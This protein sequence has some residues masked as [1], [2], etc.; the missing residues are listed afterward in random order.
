M[1]DPSEPIAVFDKSPSKQRVAASCDLNAIIAASGDNLGALVRDAPRMCIS[2]VFNLVDTQ[3]KN[4]CNEADVTKIANWFY[5]DA[6]Q[7]NPAKPADTPG[8]LNYVLY[9]RACYYVQSY[10]EKVVG[11][12]SS[13]MLTLIRYGLDKFFQRPNL[14]AQNDYHYEIFRE[15]ISLISNAHDYFNYLP[16]LAQLLTKLSSVWKFQNSVFIQKGT[17]HDVVNSM[18]DIFF[19]SHYDE[20][21]ATDYYCKHLEVAQ[22]LS[23]FMDTKGD[24]VGTSSQWLF[25]NTA[26]ELGRFSKYACTYPTISALLKKQLA[27]YNENTAPKVYAAMM[28]T[29]AYYDTK[30]CATYGFCNFKENLEKKVLPYTKTCEKTYT[31]TFKIRA[32]SI[33]DAEATEVCKRLKDQESHFHN[34]VKDSWKP[35]NPDTNA[36]IEVVIFDDVNEY[37]F[38][39]SKLFGINTDN[40]GMYIEGD[41][42]KPGNVAR[43][44]CYE[45]PVNGKF[46]VWNLEHEF[47]HYLDGRYDMV[48]DFT[49]SSSSGHTI[50]WL[51]GFGEYAANKN[52]YPS[53]QQDCKDKTYALSTIINNNYSSGQNRIYHYGYLVARFMFERHR[54]DVDAILG[55][56]RTG[57]YTPYEKFITGIGNRYDQEFSQWCDCIAKDQPC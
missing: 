15:T 7:Y 13:N 37:K 1:K 17:Q 3:A 33:S 2:E 48:G 24:L 44:F 56:F 38:Y 5:G 57:Q 32:Q 4:A 50:W 30:N 46:N 55:Y 14:D 36:L 34:L 49:A 35:V 16:T 25:Q 26:G 23:N 53:M 10:N 43:Y 22:S 47:T 39:A 6:G 19:R 27:K 40:G 11:A 51:E 20:K 41:P 29:W 18:Y 8:I 28:D 12:Y 9:L 45:R 54:N 42:S 52:Q 21:A 31:D